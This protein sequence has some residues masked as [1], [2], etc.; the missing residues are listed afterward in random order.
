[1]PP[2]PIIAN[3]FRVSLDWTNGAGQIAENVIHIRTHAAGPDA[4]AI[5]ELLQDTVTSNMWASV[6]SGGAIQQVDIIPLDGVTATESFA[7][8]GAGIWAGGGVGEVLPAVAAMVKLGT[9]LRG[10]SHRGRVFVPFT[11]EA[12]VTAGI[13]NAGT[14]ALMQTDWTAFLLALSADATTPSDLVVASYKLS[15]AA[16]VTGLLVE[17]ALGTQR[18]RQG[19]LR[20]A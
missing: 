16:A 2:L 11:S 12:G 10:R 15:S 14:A 6:G 4:S 8:G 9:G 18:R 3:T 1:M 7:T 19:R 5:F 17:S 13:L 20:G